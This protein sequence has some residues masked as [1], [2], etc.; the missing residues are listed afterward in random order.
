M[1]VQKVKIFGWLVGWLVLW[2]VNLCWVIQNRC[3]NFFFFAKN[4][5]VSSVFQPSRLGLLNSPTASLQRGKIP[6][7]KKCPGYD[8]NHSDGEVPKM[9]GLWGIQSTPSL[10]SLPGPLYPR[11]VAP[12]AVEYT[13]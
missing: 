2:H 6:H 5:M 3:Q 13:D 11:V 1:T 4:Y 7:L 10:T 9:L 8:I 12:G